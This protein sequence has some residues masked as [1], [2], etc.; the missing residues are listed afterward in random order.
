MGQDK[1]Q[2]KTERNPCQFP[3]QIRAVLVG[4]VPEPVREKHK[5]TKSSRTSSL[6][7]C[8][9]WGYVL[10]TCGDGRMNKMFWPKA[11]WVSSCASAV[12]TSKL[13]M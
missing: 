9:S 4:S 13:M 11:Q 6:C 10:S 12:A 7:A 3:D 2:K 8:S 1:E 5:T